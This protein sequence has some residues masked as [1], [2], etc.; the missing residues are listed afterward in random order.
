MFHEEN[1]IYLKNVNIQGELN[2]FTVLNVEQKILMTLLYV[3]TVA[4]LYSHQLILIVEEI[5]LAKTSVSGE[6]I[7]QSGQL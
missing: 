3:Q 5:G 7:E 2:W 1:I 6:E 4:H